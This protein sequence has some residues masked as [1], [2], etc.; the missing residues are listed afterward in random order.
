MNDFA[1]KGAEIRVINL[2]EGTTILTMDNYP[3]RDECIDGVL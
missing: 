2:F 1:V 3:T